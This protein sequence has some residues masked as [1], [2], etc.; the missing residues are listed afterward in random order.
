MNRITPGLVAL[1]LFCSPPGRVLHVDNRATVP[2]SAE[3]H[4]LKQRVVRSLVR[5]RF[6]TVEQ[7]FTCQVNIMRIGSYYMVEVFPDGISSEC[8]FGLKLKKLM[9][10][11]MERYIDCR[12]GPETDT[13]ANTP[14]H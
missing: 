13:A 10:R 12:N 2:Y 1:V 11:P 4:R 3:D 9:L 14:P 8:R 5:H 6:I 7:R